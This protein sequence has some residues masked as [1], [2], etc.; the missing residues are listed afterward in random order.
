M[1]MMLAEELYDF[2]S[3]NEAE[4]D[5]YIPSDDNGEIDETVPGLDISDE[6]GED[7][8]K[9]TEQI[10]SFEMKIDRLCFLSKKKKRKI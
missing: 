4:N 10:L 2:S 8:Q 7:C 9:I 6:E 1:K 5:D 3:E